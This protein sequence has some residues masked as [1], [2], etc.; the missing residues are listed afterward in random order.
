MKPSKTLE[1]LIYALLV[2]L[3][4][5]AVWLVLNAPANFLNARVVYQGF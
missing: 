4:L 2:V 3:S 5:I 1:Q